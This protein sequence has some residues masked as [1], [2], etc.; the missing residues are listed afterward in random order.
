MGKQKGSETKAEARRSEDDE[1][2]MTAADLKGRWPHKRLFL[3]LSLSLEIRLIFF[4]TRFFFRLP[5][6]AESSRNGFSVSASERFTLQTV[7]TH[8]DGA[9]TGPTRRP[10]KK[11]KKNGNAEAAKAHGDP[12]RPL[13]FRGTQT[14]KKKNECASNL[15]KSDI[16][17]TSKKNTHTISQVP[18]DEKE[19]DGKRIQ[20]RQVNKKKLSKNAFWNEPPRQILEEKKKR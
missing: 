7:R 3:S 13:E 6:A 17:L 1:K 5:T 19:R 10:Q 2:V 14:K 12:R 9:R 20:H 11:L 18:V 4:F 15:P 8:S 16:Q